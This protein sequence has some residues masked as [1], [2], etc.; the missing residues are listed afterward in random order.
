[1]RS[2]AAESMDYKE[3]AGTEPL[4]RTGRGATAAKENQSMI[5][6]LNFRSPTLIS[7][8]GRRP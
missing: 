2:T 8:R 7:C 3:L 1:M 5:R 4:N 6:R